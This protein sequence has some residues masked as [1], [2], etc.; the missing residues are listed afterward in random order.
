[1]NGLERLGFECA[2]ADWLEAD[3]GRAR[4]LRLMV[5][6]PG[7]PMSLDRVAH[8]R[9]GGRRTMT[10]LSVRQQISTLRSALNDLG[11]PGAIVSVR[12]VGWSVEPDVAAEIVDIVRA[13]ADKGAA[14]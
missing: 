6:S 4:L 7:Q 8:V 3:R 1:M 12:G 14:A 11:F 9:G 5:L 13:L 10:D 2:A